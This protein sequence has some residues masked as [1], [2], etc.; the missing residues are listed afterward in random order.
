MIIYYIVRVCKTDYI[1]GGIIMSIDSIVLEQNIKAIDS[2]VK[3]LEKI[4]DEWMAKNGTMN[5]GIYDMIQR[6]M[7]Q[8]DSMFQKLNILRL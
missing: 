6:L 2:R 1:K 7:N 4:Q 5:S 3:R 8:R